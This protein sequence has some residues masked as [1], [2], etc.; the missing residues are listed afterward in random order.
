MISSVL[1]LDIGWSEEFLEI[2]NDERETGVWHLSW[3]ETC[4]ALA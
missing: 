3:K 1:Q 2:V 4:D